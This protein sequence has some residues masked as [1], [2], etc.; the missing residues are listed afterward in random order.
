MRVVRVAEWE[1]RNE[2]VCE[3]VQARVGCAKEDSA[4]TAREVSWAC[5]CSSGKGQEGTARDG[6]RAGEQRDAAAWV[7]REGKGAAGGEERAWPRQGFLQICFKICLCAQR[8]KV[9]EKFA[10]ILLV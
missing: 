7:G 1:R 8:A 10:C 4:V 5:G 6:G 2:E 3:R 9:F